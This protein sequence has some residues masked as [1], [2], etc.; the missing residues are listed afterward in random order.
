MT[1]SLEDYL[2]DPCGNLSLPWWKA[3]RFHCPPDIKVLHERDVDESMLAHHREEPYFRLHHDLSHIP[4]DPL[5]GFDIQQ[6][7]ACDIPLIAHIINESY[8]DISVTPEAVA[9]WQKL[10]VYDPCLWLMVKELGK[11]EAV[12]CAI[13][14]YDPQAREGILDWVQVLPAFQRQGIG[15]AMVCALLS[16]MKGKADFATVSGQKN[17]PTNPEA[18][19]RACGFT[20][21]DVWH[22]IKAR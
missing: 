13:G 18:L 4:I 21:D 22:V 15:K 14:E 5:A 16:R 20:G 3:R 11:S 1:I 12:A 6:A 10:P 2:K 9:A 8:P 7:S 17:N 19:Y